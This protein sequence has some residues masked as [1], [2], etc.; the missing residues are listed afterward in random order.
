MLLFFTLITIIID[1]FYLFVSLKAVLKNR[2]SILHLCSILFFI[3][4]V[5]P[6]VVDMFNDVNS[7]GTHTKYLYNALTDENTAYLYNLFAIFVM[8]GL[9]STAQKFAHKRV[10][11]MFQR[12][13]AVNSFYRLCIV[14]LMFA[15]VAAVILAPTPEIYTNFSYF[16]THSYNPLAVEYLYH[17]LVMPYIIYLSFLSILVYYYLIKGST[18][19]NII[20]LLSSVICIWI[21]GKRGL[22]AFLI[23]GIL[24]VDF[25]KNQ[26]QSNWKLVKK[27]ALLSCVFIAYFAVYSMF[28]TKNTDDSFYETYDA[29]FS[30]ESE[31]K[32][33]IYSRLNGAD[34]LPYDGATLL[35][36][37]TCYIPRFLWEDKPYGFFNYLTA[38]AYNGHA[39]TFMEGSNFQVNIWSEY[40]A[41]FG[42]LG[43]ILSLLF[44]IG[45][46]RVSERSN[47]AMLNI[48]GSVFVLIYLFFGFELIVMV[49][50]YAW[51]YF[52]VFKRKSSLHRTRTTY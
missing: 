31:V 44:I 39:E 33:S 2:Y 1:L 21:D 28:T 51:L 42:L 35:Y 27:G 3:I 50:F 37:I 13:K 7:L 46:V 22:L 11:I 38:Y 20:M 5:L 30:R 29:Y 52:F 36:D 15:P 16:Y 45:I 14:L 8:V 24:L 6:L 9:T 4:Q 19:K 43:C 17:R 32:L 10:N 34:M 47:V 48:S 12:T 25:I 26:T 18:S 41:N 49:L 23:V 40:I